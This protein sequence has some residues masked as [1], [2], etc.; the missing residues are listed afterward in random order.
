MSRIEVWPEKLS[1]QPFE[2]TPS[3]YCLEPG[4]AISVTLK[5]T[6]PISAQVLDWRSYCRWQQGKVMKSH[7]RV[8]R[9]FK[10]TAS[11][12]DPPYIV[13]LLISNPGPESAHVVVKIASK[14]D[15][16]IATCVRS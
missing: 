14:V 8:A 15:A 7:F 4:E 2:T 10:Q 6:N 9:T 13:V 3:A 1:L 16:T 11:V 5:A 12:E